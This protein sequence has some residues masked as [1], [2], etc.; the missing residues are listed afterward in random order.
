MTMD[1]SNANHDN[2][3]TKLTG[4]AESIERQ[5]DKEIEYFIANSVSK[6]M[7]KQQ[8]GCTCSSVSTLIINK[9]TQLLPLFISLGYLVYVGYALYSSP[10]EAIAVTV[11]LPFV[12]Y[13]CINRISNGQFFKRMNRPLKRLC[14][15]LTPRKRVKLW[16][17]RYCFI[18][19]CVTH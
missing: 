18:S 13:I 1:G 12:L 6:R 14:I 9:S 2:S 10:K 19:N 7:P 15:F 17:R 5:L 3:E 16:I 4:V 11:F 8:I